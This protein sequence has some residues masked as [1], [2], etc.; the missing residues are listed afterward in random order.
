YAS[1]QDA[2]QPCAIEKDP[3]FATDPPYYDNV[4]YSDLSDFFYVWQRPILR[5]IYPDLYTSVLTPKQAELV[6]DKFRHGGDEP[7]RR[8]FEQ[9]FRSAFANIRAR[10]SSAYP[11]TVFYAF[12]QS[13]AADS[14]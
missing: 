7:A 5:A 10:I 6:A 2:A 12:K 4:P 8:F 3:I 13:E 1:Q 11:L 14:S 9:G